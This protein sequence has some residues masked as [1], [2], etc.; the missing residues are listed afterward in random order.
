MSKVIKTDFQ[1]K[2]ARSRPMP[3]VNVLINRS[4]EGLS[5][6]CRDLSRETFPLSNS[7]EKKYCMQLAHA[8]SAISLATC[9][10]RDIE[11]S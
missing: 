8:I 3:P 9:I 10:L 5:K 7:P 1:E 6:I 2:P 11:L 4:R